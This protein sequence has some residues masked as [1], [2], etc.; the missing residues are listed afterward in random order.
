MVLE[1][2]TANFRDFGKNVHI[3]G[4]FLVIFDASYKHSGT[5]KV[6]VVLFS[7]ML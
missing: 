6:G 7:F 5:L 1:V 4:V 3:N 2:L